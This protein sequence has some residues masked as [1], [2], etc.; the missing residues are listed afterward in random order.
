MTCCNHNCNQ[1]RSCDCFPKIT[2][3]DDE[4]PITFDVVI[5]YVIT[6]FAG[7][8]FFAS[9]AFLALW[10]GYKTGAV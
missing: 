9:L 8:G 2:L 6:L 5:E 1:G 4:P 10:L 3:E 7:I